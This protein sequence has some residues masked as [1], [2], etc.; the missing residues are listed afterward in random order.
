MSQNQ[1]EVKLPKFREKDD[2]SEF[3][4]TY[5]AAASTHGKSTDWLN[6]S[7]YD[8]LPENGFLGDDNAAVSYTHLRAHET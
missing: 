1:R 4:V 8:T 6:G 5:T 2:W 3:V 7:L